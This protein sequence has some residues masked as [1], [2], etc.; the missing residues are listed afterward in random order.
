MDAKRK[1]SVTLDAAALEAARELGVNVS[2]IADEALQRA[3]THA[4]RRHWLEENSEAF[5]A[6]SAWHER[7][8]HPLADILVGPAGTTWS[9]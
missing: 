7:N 9:D 1:T 8:G 5:A 6:Q 4:R 3:V 2:A